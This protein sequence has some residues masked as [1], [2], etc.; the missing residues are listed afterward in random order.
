MSY[1]DITDEKLRFRTKGEVLEVTPYGENIFR[2]QATANNEVEDLNWTLLPP[3]KTNVV[4]N[5]TEDGYKAQNGK[6]SFEMLLNSQFRV[7]KDGK[8]IFA[9]QTFRNLHTNITRSYKH[10]GGNFYKARVVFKAYDNEHFY[11]LGADYCDVWDLKG[12]SFDLCHRNTKCT[13]PFVYSSNGYGFFWNNPGV[14]RV[15]FSKNRTLWESEETKQLDFLIVG[16][17]TPAEVM[18]NYA[19]LTGF[20]PMMP[21]FGT[22]FWQCKL[23]YITQ[24]EVLTVA[25]EYKKRNIPIS[26]IIIDYFHWTE[27][28]EFEFDP[29]FWPNPAEMIK[30]LKEMGIEPIVSVWPTVHENT[31]YFNEATEKNLVIRTEKGSFDVFNFHGPVTYYDAT[32]PEARAFVWNLIKQSYF[33]LG[34]KTFWLDVTEPDIYHREDFDNLRYSIGNGN[35]CSMIYPYFCQKMFADGLKSE[36][37]NDACLLTRSGWAGSQR[38]HALIWSGD[39]PSK[40]ESLKI[41]VQQGLNMAMSGIPWWNSDIGGF[42]SGDGETEYF[43]ELIVRWFQFG[44]FCP[45]MRLHGVRKVHGE[46]DKSLLEPSGG[47]NEIWCWGEKVYEILKSLIELRERLRPYIKEQ[48]KLASETGTPLMRPMFY[49]FADEACFALGDQYMFGPDILFAPIVNEGQT[50]REVYLPK[51]V[52]WVNTRTKE[53]IAGGKWITCNADI[54]EF[55]AFVKKDKNVLEVF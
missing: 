33:A 8:E 23:R 39:I 13:I 16:G 41:S 19:K 44:V 51:G 9:T 18:E 31:K 21:D 54:S 20:A 37:I 29:A 45:V 55:I 1:I 52:E 35:Q 32:N 4:W 36:G 50:S 24:D 30:E 49:D 17:D 11:G 46:Q 10:A 43:R 5:K 28:G 2:V 26:A 38:Q 40:F 53:V 48:M 34:I 27:Q 7:T 3:E 25:R 47:P 14:G 6:L 22:G 12:A 15:E 42:G